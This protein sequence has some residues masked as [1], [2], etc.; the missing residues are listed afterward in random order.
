[1]NRPIRRVL[2]VDACVGAVSASSAHL[3]QG[4]GAQAQTQW[5][6]PGVVEALKQIERD[7][8]EAMVAVDLEKLNRIFADDWTSIGASGNVVTK[9]KLLRDFKSA[10]DRLEAFELGPMDVQVKGNVAVL[11]GSVTEKR[12]RGGKDVGGEYVW[13]DLMEKRNGIWVVIRSAGAKVK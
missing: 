3:R 2:L 1:M 11:H 4:Y 6:D 12:M 8:G 7:M 5:N 9:E 10:H 13:M